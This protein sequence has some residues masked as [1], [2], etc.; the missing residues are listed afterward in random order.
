M[1]LVAAGLPISSPPPRTAG[2]SG[3][4][5]G[6]GFSGI[7]DKGARTADRPGEGHAV[8][9]ED[10]GEES[11][12][13]A[14]EDGITVEKDGN[15]EEA[16]KEVGGP[17]VDT[18]PTTRRFGGLTALRLSFDVLERGLQPSP[19][20]G[21]ENATTPV[22][23]GDAETDAADETA[24]AGLAAIV[25]QP[26][27]V[28]PGRRTER[29]EKPE[30]R[31]AAAL[32]ADAPSK[33]ET[34]GDATEDTRRE[35]HRPGEISRPVARS[36]Q[37]QAGDN[38]GFRRQGGQDVLP[39]KVNVVGETNNIATA[40]P[41]NTQTVASLATAM[42]S[43]SDWSAAARELR[44]ANP[45]AETPAPGPVRDLRIQLNPAS[46]GEVN[47]RL[48]ISGEQLSV[49][50]RVDNSEAFQ[51]LS[52]DREAIATALR[53]LGFKVD[54]VTIVQ[55][56]GATTNGQ[57]AG[58]GREGG[59]AAGLSQFSEREQ[60]G[61]SGAGREGR[62][63]DQGRQNADAQAHRAGADTGGVYI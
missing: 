3:G 11:D 22:D 9:E 2:T 62:N 52:G 14:G 56:P 38:G 18:P 4:P 55:Q 16:E 59:S 42:A 19:E 29:G 28:T 8:R 63:A 60:G 26:V 41:Q 27:Q 7:L 34:E 51:R 53:A 10:I 48:R 21:E 6:D 1:S 13:A 32:V 40:S 25:P 58:G 50:I 47:A 49:E 33:A 45:A 37:D 23:D 54:D 17:D 43:N 31:Q 39:M 36:G 12:I 5:R 44:A 61:Q 35:T 30:A 20:E 15:G 24:M 46:L 57:A